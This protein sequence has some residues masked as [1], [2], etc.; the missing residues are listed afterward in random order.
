MMTIPV[1]YRQNLRKLLVEHEGLRLHPYVDTVGKTTIGVGRNL[2]D[3]G[4]SNDEAFYLLDN[5]IQYF[6]SKLNE[7][8]WFLKL[9]DARKIAL[10]DMCFNL[11]LKSF[12]EFK[13]MIA[14]IEK[15]DFD[16]ASNHM[17]DS[18]W[19]EQVGNR[20]ARLAEIVKTGEL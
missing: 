6:Y 14:A 2:D 19:H 5:D 15:N 11:G 1:E 16:D 20:A 10:I 18:K 3:R 9:N 7:F 13:N 4:I 12:L 17:L 8:D